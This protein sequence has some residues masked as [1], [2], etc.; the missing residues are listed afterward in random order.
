MNESNLYFIDTNIFLRVL[1]QENKTSFED[2]FKILEMIKQ[3][4]V[5]AFT[6]SL[7]LAEINW[8]L[9][10]LYKFSK[11][12]TVE[13]IRSILN[14]KNLKIIDK[15]DLQ[16]GINL[17]EKNKV[18]FIDALIAANDLILKKE[19]KIISYDKDFDKMG[20]IRI[21]PKKIIIKKE[22]IK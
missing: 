11:E 9:S 15:S 12:K 22:F 19:A 17:Y 1:V 2:C 18:K 8:V 6:N 13:A 7:V 4:K 16:E 21:E 20:V 14:L 5:K 10:G 3:G